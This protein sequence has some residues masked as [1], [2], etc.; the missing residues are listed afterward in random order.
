MRSLLLPALEK[1]S[2][3]VLLALYD[4]AAHRVTLSNSRAITQIELDGMAAMVTGVFDTQGN[5]RVEGKAGSARNII[6]Y[7][8]CS[9]QKDP[10]S[11][12]IVSREC[13]NINRLAFD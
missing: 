12:G 11:G 3:L 7:K 10:N 13:A 6:K 8:I 9:G 1:M 4:N 5:A 2:A